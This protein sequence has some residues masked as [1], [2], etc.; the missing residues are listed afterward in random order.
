MTSMYHIDLS[1][2]A[3]R[4][5]KKLLSSVRHAIIKQLDSLKSTPR[6]DGVKKLAGIDKLYRLRIGDYRVVYTI[7]DKQRVILVVKIGDR[8]EV[9][10]H[11]KNVKK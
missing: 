2:A 8:K 3:Q 10:R 6:P 11:L 9:Y 5:L 7:N 4:Q 1:P